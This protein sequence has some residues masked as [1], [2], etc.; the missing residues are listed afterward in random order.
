MTEDYELISAG[1]IQKGDEIRIGDSW[2]TCRG[3]TH[4]GIEIVMVIFD[5]VLTTG[6]DS[7][8]V[9]PIDL[10]IPKRV[11]NEANSNPARG[12]TGVSVVRGLPT[13]D[14][15]YPNPADPGDHPSRG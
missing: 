10:I 4:Q 7:F 8:M 11:Y 5:V 1:N 6:M 13:G 9:V 12:F 2:H 14:N 3:V 15:R